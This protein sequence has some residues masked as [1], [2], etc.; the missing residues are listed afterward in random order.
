MRLAAFESPVDVERS[1][2][3]HRFAF[4]DPCGTLRQPL[5]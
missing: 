2:I 5:K 3:L 1:G 4:H